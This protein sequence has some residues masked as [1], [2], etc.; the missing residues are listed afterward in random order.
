VK[1]IK[2][3]IRKYLEEIFIFA[4][5]AF[6]LVGTYLLSPVATWFVAGVECIGYAVL[7]ALGKRK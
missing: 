6:L 5:F 1:K 2:S 7:L 3:K 4:G